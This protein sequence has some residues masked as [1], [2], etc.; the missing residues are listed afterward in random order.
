MNIKNNVYLCCVKWDCILLMKR[1]FFVFGKCYPILRI[2]CTL[3]AIQSLMSSNE[4]SR[5]NHIHIHLV[6]YACKISTA[7]SNGSHL[8]AFTLQVRVQEKYVAY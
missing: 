5:D 4:W 7:R 1:V 8:G 6:P 2:S 3:S